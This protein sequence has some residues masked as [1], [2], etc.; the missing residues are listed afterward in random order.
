[1]PRG[2]WPPAL[3]PSRNMSCAAMRLVKKVSMSLIDQLSAAPWPSLLTIAEAVT[4]SG[5][6]RGF[7]WLPHAGPPNLLLETR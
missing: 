2:P 6:A 4:E 3:R 1:M 5:S 7:G